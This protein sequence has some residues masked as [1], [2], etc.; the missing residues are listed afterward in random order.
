MA[1]AAVAAGRRWL[2]HGSASRSRSR[3]E[4]RRAVAD[5]R[6]IFRTDETAAAY[7]GGRGP[8]DLMPNYRWYQTRS[9]CRGGPDRRFFRSG[10]AQGGLRGFHRRRQFGAQYRGGQ[11][12]AGHRW[13]HDAGRSGSFRDLIFL[14]QPI[15]GII[16]TLKRLEALVPRRAWSR[17]RAAQRRDRERGQVVAA[18][19]RFRRRPSR[20][21]VRNSAAPKRPRR[22]FS[23]PPLDTDFGRRS[24]GRS[25]SFAD[26]LQNSARAF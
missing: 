23:G 10:A 24:S 26:G 18:Q 8:H 20:W 3:A 11:K 13:R 22:I 21:R 9:H 16:E 25:R 14:S 4:R 1:R 6:A 5:R 7:C 19:L 2:A 15:S 12:S 17:M